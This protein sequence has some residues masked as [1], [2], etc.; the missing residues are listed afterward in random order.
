MLLC[1]SQHVWYRATVSTPQTNDVATLIYTSGTTGKP[2]VPSFHEFLLVPQDFDYAA[3]DAVTCFFLYCAKKRVP[4]LL[5]HTLQLVEN[6]IFKGV[7]LSHGNIVSNI[8]GLKP[9]CP[10]FKEDRSLC[11]LPWAHVF[12]QVISEL[13]NE[14]C[15]LYCLSAQPHRF[16]FPG[17]TVELHVLLAWG[18]S[19]VFVKDNSMMI[20]QLAEIKPTMFFAVPAVFNKI[21]QGRFVNVPPRRFTI[22]HW[23]RP[24]V[25][26]RHQLTIG[27]C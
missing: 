22:A 5:C 10:V 13:C 8:L 26:H 20:A 7:M 9:V 21:Y 18:A 6:S 15:L 19:I 23:H 27:I 4:V 17:Q 2:K 16:F 1:S 11:F 3:L 25:G 14:G 12:G 24:T